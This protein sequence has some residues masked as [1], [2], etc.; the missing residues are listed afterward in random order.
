MVSLWLKLHS[1]DLMG[2]FIIVGSIWLLVCISLILI[3][4]Q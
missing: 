1:E 3:S 4:T 2:R